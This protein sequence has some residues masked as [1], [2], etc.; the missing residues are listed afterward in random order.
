MATKRPP[1][2][3][4]LATEPE[5]EDWRRRR[6]WASYAGLVTVNPTG[7]TPPA[8]ARYNDQLKELDAGMDDQS[9][10]EEAREIAADVG[11]LRNFDALQ[12]RYAQRKP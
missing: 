7:K 11:I 1:V 9:F 2:A 5:P 12:I 8:Y 4:R 6:R 10:Y 3:L